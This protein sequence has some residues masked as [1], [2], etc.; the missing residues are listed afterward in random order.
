[1]AFSEREIRF[2]GGRT[3][4]VVVGPGAI[5]PLVAK[6]A[7]T[8]ARR[9]VVIADA[10]VAAGPAAALSA[11]LQAAGVATTTLTVPSGE[12]AKSAAEVVR[13]WEALAGIPAD[14]ATQVVAVGGGV[15]GD[16]A[17][18]VAATFVRGLPVWQVPT[19]LMAQVDSSIGGK[20][21]IN[22]AAGKNLVGAFWQPLGVACDAETMAT[23][24]DREYR[25]GLAEVVKYGVILDAD[26]FTWL[27]AH[28]G[29]IL[30]RNAAA[31]S[32]V[33]ARCVDLKARVVEEDEQERSGLRAILN[34]GHTV[35]HAL[36]TL[37]GYGTLLHGEAVAIGMTAAARIALATG[38]WG[39]EPARRQASLLA[40]FDLPLAAPRGLP[41]IATADILAAMGRD[42]KTLHGKVRFILPTAIGRVEIADDV[43]AAIVRQIVA[44][45]IPPG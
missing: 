10:A 16:L 19:T 22:L 36:E 1:V 13:L 17:G 37:A 39:V 30:A 3:C 11:A 2:S 15:V 6:I 33:V 8:G 9:V 43:D 20:T 26:F 45:L 42:K 4:Q 41:P 24:P 40:R 7:A 12:P 25:S 32:H 18:F 31:V 28:A 44:E 29:E 23:L 21:G 38:R 35:G 5:K 34:Y 14:R 27:E